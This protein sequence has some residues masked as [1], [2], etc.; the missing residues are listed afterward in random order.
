MKL[1]VKSLGGLSTEGSAIRDLGPQSFCTCVSIKIK[2]KEKF[3]VILTFGIKKKK[4][5]MENTMLNLSNND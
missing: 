4:P 2:T 1:S 5:Q 3:L